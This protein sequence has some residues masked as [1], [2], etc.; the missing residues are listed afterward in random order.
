MVVVGAGVIVATPHYLTRARS[1]ISG[2][3]EGSG[4]RG[5]LQAREHLLLQSISTALHNPIFGVGPG[6]FQVTTGEWK[7]AHNS[8]TELAA[9][10]GLP[11][12]GLFLGVLILTFRKIKSV[13][14]LPGFEIDESIRL[15]TSALWASLA[16]YSTGAMFAS[17]EYNLFPY[18]M[19]GYV[20]A[21]Y[22][23]ATIAEPKMSQSDEKGWQR[24][25]L[26]TWAIRKP[27]SVSRR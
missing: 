26:E 12:L 18:F 27:E 8:Y 19:V 22:Q 9:E 1:L 21:L 4:D 15:W 13:R 25:K 6:N 7:V 3:I 23:I 2:N 20:S 10:G 17:T 11:A 14:K 16:A 5:S 24:R